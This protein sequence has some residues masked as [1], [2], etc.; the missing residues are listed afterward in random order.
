[1]HPA[2]WTR[3]ATQLNEEE[4][5]QQLESDDLDGEEV[6]REHALRLLAQKRFAPAVNQGGG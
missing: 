5:V 6:D 3:A 2:I 4:N 1:V